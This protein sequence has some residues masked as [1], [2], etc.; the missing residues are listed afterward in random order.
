MDGLLSDLEV[1]YILE[2]SKKMAVGKF[3]E[4]DFEPRISGDIQPKQNYIVFS[5]M[6]LGKR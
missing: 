3:W 2:W 4:L 1:I 5:I 6:D